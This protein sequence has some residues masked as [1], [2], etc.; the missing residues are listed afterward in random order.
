MAQSDTS[1]K[2]CPLGAILG[3]GLFKIFI[4]NTDEGIE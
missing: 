2:G 3:P 4:D 1:D